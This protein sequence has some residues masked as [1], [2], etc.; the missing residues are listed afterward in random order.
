MFE[1]RMIDTE[2][3]GDD[4]APPMRIGDTDPRCGPASMQQFNGED[5]MLEERQAQQKHYMRT[6]LEHQ[7]FEKSMIS[8]EHAGDD[9]A[10]Q[11]EVGEITQMRNDIEER[12]AA[13]RGEMRKVQQQENLGK[14][15]ERQQHRMDE[16]ELNGQM[17][18][19]EIEHHSQDPFLNENT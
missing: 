16:M 11:A 10:W 18:A 7:M 6:V 9:A 12:E 4:K 1:K 2:N 5:L 19:A 15:A 17:N 14:A 8:T 13:L 3:D